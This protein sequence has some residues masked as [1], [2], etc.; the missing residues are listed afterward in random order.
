[1]EGHRIPNKIESI[2]KEWFNTGC[3]PKTPPEY[4]KDITF[5]DLERN[6]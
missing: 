1:M 4:I 2:N 6:K 3:I 5:E